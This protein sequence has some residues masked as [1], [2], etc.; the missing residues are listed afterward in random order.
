MTAGH[1]YWGELEKPNWFRG[2]QVATHMPSGCLY[3]GCTIW[4]D[5]HPSD[6]ML[7]PS[8]EVAQC[9]LLP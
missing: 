8:H 7:M 2:G 6:F 9:F 4:H 1:G 3:D 5:C